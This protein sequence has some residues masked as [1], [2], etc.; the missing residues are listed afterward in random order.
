VVMRELI[1][2]ETFMMGALPNDSVGSEPKHE[3][4][5]RRA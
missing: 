3:W 1:A 5:I 2:S 4:P